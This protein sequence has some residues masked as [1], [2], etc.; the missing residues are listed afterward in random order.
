MRSSKYHDYRVL[1]IALF[2]ILVILGLFIYIK[3]TRA[4]HEHTADQWTTI[5]E[6]TCTED[7][8]EAKVC[9]DP[10]CKGEQFDERVIP[11][12]GHTERNVWTTAK[13]AT[14]TEQGIENKLCKDCGIVLD[15]RYT[16][17]KPHATTTKYEN[18]VYAT[19]TETGS[20][21]VVVYCK[22]CGFEKSRDSEVIDAKGH[23]Y[24]PGSETTQ[25]AI[26]PTHTKEGVELNFKKCGECGENILQT[27]VNEI[28]PLGHEYTWEIQYSEEGEF[29]IIAT[30]DCDEEGNKYVY[31]EADGLTATL[32]TAVPTCC[33]KLYHLTVTLPD[34]TVIEDS[35]EVDPDPHSVLADVLDPETNEVVDKVH[36]FVTNFAYQD[37]IGYYYLYKD[38]KDIVYLN[39]EEN[40]WDSNGFA[41]GGFKCSVCEEK[42]CTEC[43]NDYWYIVRIYD[44][45]YDT[46]LSGES[47]DN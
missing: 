3:C 19:C 14:C 43:N 26:E 39:F 1:K 7:G 11:A 23:D 35:Y 15:T 38:V 13:K 40:V 47:V 46:R 18:V 5:K 16:D 24:I 25:V 41:Y 31:T 6:A 8:L 44:P 29:T 34:G 45:K 2:I 28:D 22:D 37:E 10:E 33:L 21:E 9:T 32:D 4:L 17:V 12:T 42:M 27:E 36:T 30:C 20:R